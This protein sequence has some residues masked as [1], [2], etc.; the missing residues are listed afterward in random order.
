MGDGI[1]RI[2]VKFMRERI[3]NMMNMIV[4]KNKLKKI[5]FN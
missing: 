1:H 5:M 4:L 3:S 2:V